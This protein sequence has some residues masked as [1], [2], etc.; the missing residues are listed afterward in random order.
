[1]HVIY[2]LTW[3]MIAC[4]I[5]LSALSSLIGGEICVVLMLFGTIFIF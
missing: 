4:G 1:M 3:E 2:V 5:Y